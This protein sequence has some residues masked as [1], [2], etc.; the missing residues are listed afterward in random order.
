VVELAGLSE[1]WTD[2]KHDALWAE[3]N[4]ID[5]VRRCSSAEV[6]VTEEVDEAEPGFNDTYYTV[7]VPDMDA[8]GRELRAEIMEVLE[9]GLDGASAKS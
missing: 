4:G 2:E 5:L 1:T 3:V 9:L 7:T 6:E 8:F